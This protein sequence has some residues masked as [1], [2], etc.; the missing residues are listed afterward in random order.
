MPRERR[1]KYANDAVDTAG[2]ASQLAQKVNKGQVAVTDIDKNLGKLDQTYLSDTLLQQIAGTTPVNAVPADGGVT[3]P[4]LADKSVTHIKTDFLE[5]QL[6][7]FTPV[8]I[9]D[10]TKLSAK[11]EMA[12]LSTG[13]F[14]STQYTTSYYHTDYLEVRPNLRYIRKYQ[15]SFVFY[16]ANKVFIS[17]VETPPAM[18]LN[19]ISGYGVTTPA[20]C[21]YMVINVIETSKDAEFLYMAE[22]DTTNPINYSLKIPKLDLYN[23]IYSQFLKGK[24]GV[25]FGDSITEFGTYPEQIGTLTGADVKNVGFGGTRLV[26]HDGVGHYNHF[27]MSKLATAITTGVWTD[28]DTAATAIGGT[29]PSI[30]ARLKAV[31]WSGI[32]FITMLY[33]TND[34]TSSGV[35]LGEL[36]STNTEKQVYGA[37]NYILQ[38]ILTTYPHIKIYLLTPVY[39]KSIANKTGDSDTET[40]GTY[41]TLYMREIVEAIRTKAKEYH[42]PFKDLYNE[43]NINK[44]NQATYLTSD[45]V[46]PNGAG[47]TLLAQKIARFLVST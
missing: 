20:N 30:L 3:T 12:A 7:P 6:L 33:G 44:Y 9:Y 11:G 16:D 31:N 38:T 26:T 13:A 23:Q 24:K 1:S 27:S 46:H 41:S 14:V 5:Y 39:R 15:L 8:N 37:L 22:E 28:Q 21:K 35:V 45:G 40:G 2:L 42:V 32:D 19:G 18:S 4:K 25:C 29:Y 36:T 17:S 47:F 34:F 10:A 43:S